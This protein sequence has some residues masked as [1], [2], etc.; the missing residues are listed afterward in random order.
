M[1]DKNDGVEYW[2][3]KEINNWEKFAASQVYT[4]QIVTT[5]LS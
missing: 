3:I 4:T 1:R 5:P 2:M